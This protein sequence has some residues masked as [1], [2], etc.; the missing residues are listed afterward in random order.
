MNTLFYIMGNGWHLMGWS[1]IIWL[2]LIALGFWFLITLTN[3]NIS[4]KH[5]H[6][7]HNES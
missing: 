4:G 1:W 3:R 6:K 7:N 5:Q 2:T